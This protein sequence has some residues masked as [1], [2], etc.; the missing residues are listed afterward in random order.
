VGLCAALFVASHVFGAE[1]IRVLIITG[2]HGYETNQFF[3]LFKSIPDITYEAAEHPK[4]HA[5]LK[6]DAAGKYDV[7]LLY[8]MWAKITE[9]AKADFIARLKE[10]KGLVA[11]HHCLGSYQDWPEYRK[12]IGGK[13]LMKKEVIDG[14][15]KP[16][17]TYKHDV[18]FKV[19]VAPNNH[20]IIRGLKDFSIHDETYGGF[21]VSPGVTPLL[22]TDDPTSSKTVAWAKTYEG[23]RVATIQLG[24]DHLAYEN[25]NFRKLVAQAIAW[26][27]K[28]D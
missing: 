20:P 14:V 5:L 9:E 18:D 13:Y 7:I 25:P 21:D 22:T 6:A 23:T 19:Q 2:G 11:M 1:K 24:H 4:A 10:G 8:D 27:V 26:T 15:E 12:I 28:R 17:S 3:Q 16:A